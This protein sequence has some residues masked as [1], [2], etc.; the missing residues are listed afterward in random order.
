MKQEHSTAIITIS[1]IVLLVMII[2]IMRPQIGIT[3]S[4]GATGFS[5]PFAGMFAPAYNPTN[6]TIPPPVTTPTGPSIGLPPPPYNGNPDVTHNMENL[7][8][9][10]GPAY[11]A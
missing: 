8:A 6:A 10:M 4:S 1:V 11:L 3:A 5:N 7:P 9:T 2:I